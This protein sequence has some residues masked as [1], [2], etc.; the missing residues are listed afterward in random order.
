MALNCRSILSKP[1][2]EKMT[3]R[4]ATPR[5]ASLIAGAI[6]V[7]IGEDITNELAGDHH[8]REDIHDLFRRLA[9]RDDTQYSYKNT[10]IATDHD[11]LPMGVTISYDGA[12]L[13][14]LRRSFFHEAISTLGW[15]MSE[16]DIEAVPGETEPDEVY[17]DTLMV[18]PQYRRQGVAKELLADAKKKAERIGKPLGLLCDLDNARAHRLYESVG[19]KDIGLRPFAGHTMYHM[20]AE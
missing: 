12:D 4:N 10:R 20:Q 7:A 13:K 16:D 19:F 2:K 17:L 14:T 15:T 9:E 18:L 1:Q 8:T 3:I 6:L 5:D 11:G